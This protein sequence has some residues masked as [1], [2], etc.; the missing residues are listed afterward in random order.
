MSK[1][2]YQNKVLPI[3]LLQINTIKHIYIYNLIKL[4]LL[5]PP[6]YVL[7]MFVPVSDQFYLTYFLFNV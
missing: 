4:L 1:V 7:K 5:C 3:S 2:D 6:H